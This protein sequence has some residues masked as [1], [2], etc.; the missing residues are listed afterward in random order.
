MDNDKM[1]ELLAE[2]KKLQASNTV[3]EKESWLKLELKEHW[4]QVVVFLTVVCLLGGVF[5]EMKDSIKAWLNKSTS[6]IVQVSPAPVNINANG[7]ETSSPAP[8]YV[9]VNPTLSERSTATLLPS[10]SNKTPSVKVTDPEPVFMLNYNGHKFDYVPYTTEQYNFDPKTWQFDYTRKSEMNVNVEVPTP[11][12]AIGMGYGNHGVA[13]QGDYRIGTS[14]FNVW[15][16]ADS[17]TVAAGLKFTQYATSD[18]KKTTT[19]KTQSVKEV[20]K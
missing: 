16:Y 17:K 10:T 2:I 5:F 18:S 13:I 3:E 12:Y 7:K 8:F 1:E 11:R 20:K 15:G 19:D 9:N 4:K 6:N 14:P